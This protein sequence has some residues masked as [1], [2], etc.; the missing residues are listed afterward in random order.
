MAKMNVL[1]AGEFFIDAIETAER[2]FG[3]IDNESTYR[4]ACIVAEHVEG[5]LCQL[6]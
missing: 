5:D 3:E 6:K 1:Q 2:L 4:L